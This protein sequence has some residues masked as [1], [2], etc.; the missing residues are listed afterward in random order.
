MGP[1]RT[2]KSTSWSSAGNQSP[3]TRA[4]FAFTSRWPSTLKLASGN[5]LHG[6]QDL[7]PAMR[8]EPLTYYHRA[9]PIGDVMKA[10]APQ[11]LMM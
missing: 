11:S 6:Q 10:W 7:S 4:P 2:E 3:W 9:S 5:T 8:R 1:A